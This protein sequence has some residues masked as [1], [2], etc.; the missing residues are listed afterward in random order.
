MA[1]GMQSAKQPVS[2]LLAGPYGHPYHPMLVT[3]PIGAWLASLLFDI[4]SH[5][6]NRPGFLT[7]GSEWLIAA[8]VLAAVAAGVAGFADLAAIPS[9]TAACRT[10]YAHMYINLTLMFAYT[11]NFVWRYRTYSH[12]APVGVGML[13]LSMVCVAAL[14]VSGYLGGKLA[15]RYGVR[16]ADELTQAEGYVTAGADLAGGRRGPAERA[17]SE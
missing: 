3:L 12:G 14:G 16:V 15:F 5:L 7:Q 8:G 2:A 9:G 13:A 6:V 17:R 10:A 4:A 11:G 1:H